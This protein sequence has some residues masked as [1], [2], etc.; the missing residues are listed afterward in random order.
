MYRF[1]T[2]QRDE[3]VLKRVSDWCDCG[4]IRYSDVT[5]IDGECFKNNNVNIKIIKIIKKKI[6][7][8]TRRTTRK[9]HVFVPT[10]DIPDGMFEQGCHATAFLLSGD[11]KGF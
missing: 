8:R 1:H 4:P 5:P 3:K 9:N 6:T 2:G 11:W 7:K 10:G